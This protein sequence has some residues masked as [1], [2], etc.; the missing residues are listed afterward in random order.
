MTLREAE[1][2]AAAIRKHCL[3]C[4]GGCRDMVD[5]CEV[6]SCTLYPYRQ[7]DR[8]R[9]PQEGPEQVSVFDGVEGPGLQLEALCTQ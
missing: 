4:S 6:K 5:R 1:K 9:R 2:M 7:L 8:P 3:E